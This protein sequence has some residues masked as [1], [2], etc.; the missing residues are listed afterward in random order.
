M[1][2][3]ETLRHYLSAFLHLLVG[4]PPA[5]PARTPLDVLQPDQPVKPIRHLRLIK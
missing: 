5:P 2:P 4:P 1:K 3:F